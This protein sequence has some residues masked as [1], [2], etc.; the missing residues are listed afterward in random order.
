MEAL[1][2]EEIKRHGQSDCLKLIE[3]QRLLDARGLQVVLDLY[4]AVAEYDGLPILALADTLAIMAF[5]ILAF[6]ELTLGILT[7]PVLALGELTLGELAFGQFAFGEL[8]LRQ[9]AP[10]LIVVGVL[11]VREFAVGQFVVVRE[12]DIRLR[13]LLAWVVQLGQAVHPAPGHLHAVAA[14]LFLQA[15]VRYVA[16]LLVQAILVA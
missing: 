15:V 10:V 5:G 14:R 12:R 11:V 16:L 8:A 1:E 9:H 2:G 13:G 3:L 7:L 6:P 4:G